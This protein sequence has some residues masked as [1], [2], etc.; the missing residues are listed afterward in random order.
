MSAA[1]AVEEVDHGTSG[2]SPKR[3][4]RLCFFRFVYIILRD[5]TD[6][7]REKFSRRV[8]KTKKIDPAHTFYGTSAVKVF[9]ALLPKRAL[10]GD[11]FLFGKTSLQH[12]SRKI[13]N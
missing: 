6:Y 13:P 5:L 4:M 12:K 8:E 2:L 9:T 3:V 1:S 11:H 10:Y 7:R